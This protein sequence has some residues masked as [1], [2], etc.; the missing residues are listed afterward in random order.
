MSLVELEKKLK[1]LQ[2]EYML[3]SDDTEKIDLTWKISDLYWAVQAGTK[4]PSRLR[5]TTKDLDSISKQ[6]DNFFKEE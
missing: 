4:I 5:K 2:V 6:F 3:S 1:I